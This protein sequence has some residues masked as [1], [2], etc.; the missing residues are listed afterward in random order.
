LF[1]IRRWRLGFH[2]DWFRNGNAPVES[3]FA[4]PAAEWRLVE[5]GHERIQ[6]AAPQGMPD[7]SPTATWTA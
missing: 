1:C 3:T 7:V 4:P 6:N 5:H 2:L